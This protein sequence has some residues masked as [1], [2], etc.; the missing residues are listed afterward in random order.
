MGDASTRSNLKPYDK[1]VSFTSLLCK[2][3]R[4]N[5]WFLNSIFLQ[6]EK[7]GNEQGKLGRMAT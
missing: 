6:L 2:V 1:F 7:D 3:F 4:E 5:V